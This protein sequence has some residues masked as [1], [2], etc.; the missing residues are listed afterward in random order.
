MKRLA[1]LLL[2]LVLLAGCSKI[3]VKRTKDFTYTGCAGT[4]ASM[5]Y[6]EPSL[7]KLKYED[8]GLRVVRTN[9]ELNC[10]IRERGL[11]CEVSIDGNNIY[12]QVDFEKQ[13]DMVADCICPVDEIT[14]VVTGL[15]EGKEYNFHYR[16][17]DRH[18]S[19]VTFTFK[20]GLNKIYDVDAL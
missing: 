5:F 9:A 1:F 18:L 7:L 10:A 2:G 15:V 17:M 6:D 16:G 19:P 12:Y 20:K 11:A 3:H 14:S 8:G 13:L 4:R